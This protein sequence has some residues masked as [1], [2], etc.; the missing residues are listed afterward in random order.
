MVDQANQL[1]SYFTTYPNRTEKEF[2]PGIFWSFDFILVNCFEIYKSIYSEFALNSKGNRDPNAHRRFLEKL[3]DEIF[4][5]TDETF[6]TRPEKSENRYKY[7]SRCPGRPLKSSTISQNQKNQE[8]EPISLSLEIN[9]LSTQGRPYKNIP[10]NVEPLKYHSYVK[11][12]TRSY[13]LG[14]NYLIRQDLQSNEEKA[15]E[16]SDFSYPPTLLFKEGSLEEIQESQKSKYRRIRGINTYWKCTKC[17][18]VCRNSKCWEILHR[19]IIPKEK[20]R[21]IDKIS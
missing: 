21:K 19:A 14:C 10:V 4:L 17:G 9:R 20:K 11:T 3:V 18:P 7:T 13:C 16:K 12:T 15:S 6:E 5:Y 1:R 2:L 8:K